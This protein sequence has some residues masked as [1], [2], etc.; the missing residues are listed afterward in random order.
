MRIYCTLFDGGY[1]ARGM[2]LAESLREH[3]S[4]CTL[5]ILCMDD[6][7]ET[8]LKQLRIPNVVPISLFE[9]EKEDRQ[10][11]NVKQSRSTVEYYFTCK[12]SLIKYVLAKN[13]NCERVTYLDA[14]L[15]FFSDPVLLDAEIAKSSV[16]VI[17][18][19]FSANN[20]RLHKFGKFNA[21]WLSVR[22][23]NVGLQC[24]EWWRSKC[25]EWCYDEV[26]CDRYADQKYLDKFPALFNSTVVQNIGANLAPWNLGNYDLTQ[27]NEKI[28][29][30]GE[31]VI[32][33]HFQGV[34][35]LYG[36]IVE[37]GLGLYRQELSSVARNNLFVPYL[38]KW[39]ES[40]I[41]V[42]NIRQTLSHQSSKKKKSII[43]KR[44]KRGSFL[45]R[46]R[47]LLISIL[48]NIRYKTLF[49]FHCRSSENDNNVL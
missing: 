24:V 47:I 1:I 31:P 39:C 8:L 10:L 11:A 48:R 12:A 5:Y 7:A 45:S 21:G 35:R 44:I 27:K 18:H 46:S 20:Q 9:F 2:V 13:P 3:C 4:P 14:D 16:A 25:L 23:D 33:F 36:S 37:S 19:R 42:N 43:S 28:F 30:D 26:E 6:D 29:V 40:E 49:I 15:F 34:K 41:K 38:E 17:E 22:N 32:F